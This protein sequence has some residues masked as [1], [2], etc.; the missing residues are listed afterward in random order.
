MSAVHAPEHLEQDVALPEWIEAHE[1]ARAGGFTF[2]DFLTAVDETDRPRGE[3]AAGF[4][5]VSR[6]LD[7]RE[8]GRAHV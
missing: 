7:V 1:R 6:L 5:L 2:F 3:L 4:D 8:I